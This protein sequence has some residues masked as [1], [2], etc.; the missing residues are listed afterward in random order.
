V[1]FIPLALFAGGRY[2]MVGIAIALLAVHL[3]VSLS[4][5]IQSMGIIRGL[6]RQ[7]G[8]SDGKQ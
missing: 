2:G 3:P 4:N 1:A 5:P 7:A 8:C 6:K